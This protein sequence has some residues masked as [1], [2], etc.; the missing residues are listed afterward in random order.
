[1]DLLFELATWHAL[2]KLRL[3]SDTS[4]KI[5]ETSTTRLGQVFHK[6]VSKTCAAFVTK[7]LPQEEAARGRR[8]AAMDAKAQSAKGKEKVSSTSKKAKKGSEKRNAKGKQKTKGKEKA[9]ESSA[10]TSKSGKAEGPGKPA[11][12]GGANR[13]HFNLHTFKMHSLGHYVD[14]IRMYGTTDNYSTQVVSYIIS[15]TRLI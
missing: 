2:A 14:A 11:K 4:L 13:R 1:M 9:V 7:D 3:H 6:F 5:F 15:F 12:K 8:K 10:D